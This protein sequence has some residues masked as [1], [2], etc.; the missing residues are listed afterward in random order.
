M[1]ILSLREF[2]QD[3]HTHIQ[4]H[5]TYIVYTFTIMLVRIYNI[6]FQGSL[7][8]ASKACVFINVSLTLMG[9]RKPPKV[10]YCF[11]ATASL[12]PVAVSTRI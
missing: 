6:K 5:N 2:K 4:I 8:K 10:E 3:A 1:Y 9:Y 11:I 12:V 7:R